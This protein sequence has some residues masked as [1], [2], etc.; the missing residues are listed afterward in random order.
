MK[1]PKHYYCHRSTE[2]NNQIPKEYE[3]IDKI[4][5]GAFG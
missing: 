3:L 5:E 1:K 2:H 4:G